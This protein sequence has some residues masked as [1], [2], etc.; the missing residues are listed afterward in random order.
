M[1]MVFE[2]EKDFNDV[3]GGRAILVSDSYFS[4]FAPHTIFSLTVLSK[5]VTSQGWKGM[6]IYSCNP[7]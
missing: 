3:D 5:D 6:N 2:T 4:F 7:C 1:G